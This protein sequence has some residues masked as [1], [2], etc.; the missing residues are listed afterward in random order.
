MSQPAEDLR[1]QAS[2]LS[3]DV[4]EPLPGS[5]KI[6]QTGSRA[7]L[8]VGMREVEQS[9]SS[10][11]F[12]SG[13]NPAIPIYDTSG[14]Y[15]DP[16]AAIDI[17]AGLAP[18]REAWIRERGD[19]EALEAP[20]S[21]YGRKR[22]ADPELQDI[23]MTAA[24]PVRRAR[25]GG[26]VTQMHYARAGII[27]PE[28][29]YIAIR[30]NAGLEALRE[31]PAFRELLKRHPG[32]PFGAR[33]PETVTAEFV[34]EEVAA[35]RAIIPANINHP[36]LEPMIIGR[37]F[38]VKINANIGNSAVASS[39]A[40][41][42]EKMAWAVRWGGDTVMDLSTG[43]NIHETRE[44]IIRNS[45]VPI[46]TVPIYQALEKV[47]GRAEELTWEIYRDT[48]VEQA[49]QGVDYFTVH[50]GVRLPYIPADGGPRHR[51]R[52]ARRLHP[53]QVVP[54]AP[55]GELPVHALRGDLR[56]AEAVRRVLLAGRRAAPGLHR[57]R[58][59]RGPVR[60]AGN[61]R[62]T[63]P[64]RLGARRAGHDRRAGPHPHAHDPG[65]RG[66]GDRRLPGSAVL[67]AWDRLPR[68]SRPATTT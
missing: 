19:S 52:V 33:L 36:E 14:P 43:R 47:D 54:G 39:I 30:E 2:R 31:D 6:Y 8:R 20:T 10:T 13:L 9:A 49:E 38:R 58:Q 3:E 34:R 56:T 1:D 55:P 25:D 12:G 41:E 59:R 46:G 35:G 64:D 51:H 42:V 28:M 61:A 67:H 26:A 5:R 4:T 44:W 57:R 18:M 37:N 11:S 17:Q 53:G 48:L 7:D 27:T 22:L 32:E 65:E 24:R 63:D 66:T 21:E 68:T 23:R 40:E 16:D 60:G 50:A 62:R 15:T 29:E 45:P